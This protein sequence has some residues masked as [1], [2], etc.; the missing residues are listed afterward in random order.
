M[1]LTYTEASGGSINFTSDDNA[2]SSPFLYIPKTEQKS[3]SPSKQ[4]YITPFLFEDGRRF[5]ATAGDESYFPPYQVTDIDGQTDLAV[6]RTYSATGSPIST[7]SMSSADDEDVPEVQSLIRQ[8]ASGADR[9]QSIST[10]AYTSIDKPAPQR[11][12]ASSRTSSFSIERRRQ[13][14]G[15][16]ASSRSPSSTRPKRSVQHL[17]GK[18]GTYAKLTPSRS[19]VG[20]SGRNE[21]DLLALH[22]ESCLLFSQ[23]GP[24]KELSNQNTDSDRTPLSTRHSHSNKQSHQ[25]SA[26]SSPLLRP[27]NT[28]TSPFQSDGIPS[29]PINQFTWTPIHDLS[30]SMADATP[31][32]P[33]PSLPKTVIDWTSPST[34][35]REY[36]KIDRASRGIRGAWR[37][38]APQWCQSKDARAPFF[39]ECK[40]GHAKD[41]GSVRRFR[42]DIPEEEE[43][44]EETEE[45]DPRR[46]AR[47]VTVLRNGLVSV[48]TRRKSENEAVRSEKPS[49]VIKTWRL[50]HRRNSS[51]V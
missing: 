9:Q 31:L 30:S 18:S 16:Q 50:N 11:S 41:D 20:S 28:P 51:L 38:L 25:H 2:V 48:L 45:E 34:R 40:A 8:A 47:G 27:E 12:D 17:R 37:K 49:A 33:P 19:E 4:S 1:A 29:P 23:T 24:Y 7:F 10:S 26:S 15:G 39:E 32:P 44:E 46:Q 42:M 36:E 13:S 43:E 3:N 21:R 35:R 6:P 22:R 14:R 5:D